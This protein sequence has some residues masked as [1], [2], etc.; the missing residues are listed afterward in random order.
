MNNDYRRGSA[1]W[2]AP[3]EREEKRPAPQEPPAKRRGMP[4]GWRIALGAL[5]A[6]GLIIGSSLWFSGRNAADPDSGRKS[7]AGDSGFGFFLPGEIPGSSDGV[8]EIPGADD[9]MPDNWKDYFD[10]FY[11]APKSQ[12]GES[13]IP[14]A[15]ERPDWKLTLEP[16]D[17]EEL[18]LQEIYNNCVDS[19]VCI[20]CY[21]DGKPGYY[22]GSGIVMSED[23]LI[24]TNAHMVEGCDS[25]KVTLSDNT[26]YPALLIGADWTTDLAVLK[27]A[28]AGLHP[29]VF[30]ES[31]KLTIGESV[32]AIGNPLGEEFRATMTNGIVSGIDRGIDF[33][34]HNISLLQTNTAINEGSS[35]GALFNM[36]GQVVGVT[37][38]KMMSN[39]SSIEGIGFA[40][41]SSTVRMVA[42]ALIEKGE[43]RGRPAIG[44]TVGAIAEEAAK[45]YD[46]PD[47]LYVSAVTEG[48]DAW[49]KGIREG[50][51]ITAVNGQPA[52]TTEDVL[53]V[54]D[55]LL[56]GDSITFTIW[57]D[58]DS[59]D[60][61]VVVGDMNDIY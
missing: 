13:N 1:D 57:R 58:G 2:Y 21:Q 28:A 56:V 43:V 39:Y 24:L 18:S 50:D 47:G 25:A 5:A 27:I 3:L 37:N 41:P 10:S 15:E 36:Y 35:G 59:F 32:A 30:G 44:V 11:T 60:L 51:I 16:A 40:I 38:M 54:R 4:V 49:K 61:D 33:D 26:E 46:L 6:L 7:A 53:K 19:I 9:I 31:D 22:W 55:T 34:G 17:G 23:G 29:A 12:N 42:N 14:L 20:R 45:H 48:T 8:T 52:R